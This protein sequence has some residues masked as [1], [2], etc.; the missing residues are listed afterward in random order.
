[1]P[2]IT[3][4]NLK[5]VIREEALLYLKKRLKPLTKKEK[6]EAFPGY[7]NLISL[8]RG[9]FEEEDD[10]EP[11]CLPGNALHGE[12]GTFQDG[13]EAGSWS[14]SNPEGK[15]GCDYGKLSKKGS[16]QSKVWV[17]QP[18]GR[19]ERGNPNKKAKHKC[20]DGSLS[21]RRGNQTEIYLASLI[22]QEIQKAFREVQ[23]SGGCSFKELL[24]AMSAW[25]SA[26]KGKK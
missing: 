4:S 10:S 1:M 24:R 13:S 18:C 21:E 5:K 8:S 14:I 2:T 25:T 16:S 22:R 20:K 23:K 26:S 19:A 11:Q 12:D 7:G 6:D 15:K 9:I 17:K 3:I